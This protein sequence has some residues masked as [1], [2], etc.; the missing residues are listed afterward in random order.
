MPLPI[1][2]PGRDQIWSDPDAF[3]A[4]GLAYFD[5]KRQAGQKLTLAGLSL[6]LGLSYETFCQYRHKKTFSEVVQKLKAEIL[7]QAEN[8]IWDKETHP[9]AKFHAQQL[10][11]SEKTLVESQNT[12]LNAEVSPTDLS[13][14]TPEELEAFQALLAKLG[15]GNG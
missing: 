10:G 3:Y 11:M 12:N 14:L 13:K 9:G 6:A 1:P 2:G 8:L 15:G 5:K 4:C 7:E